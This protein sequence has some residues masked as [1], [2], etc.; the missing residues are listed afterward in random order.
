MALT[1]TY[2]YVKSCDGDCHCTARVTI[3]AG[4]EASQHEFT[5]DVAAWRQSRLSQTDRELLAM[6]LM[7]AQFEQVVSEKQ[8]TTLKN[9]DLKARLDSVE[10]IEVPKDVNPAEPVDS[11]EPVLKP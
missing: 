1:Y 11:S 8:G 9:T 2:E 4:G 7:R 5:I 10:T 6:L 3:D